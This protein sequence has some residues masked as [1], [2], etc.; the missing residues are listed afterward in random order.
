[1]QAKLIFSTVISL[2]LLSLLIKDGPAWAQTAFNVV[3]FLW[4][5]RPRAA[6]N[7]SDV[8]PWARSCQR[9]QQ[10]PTVP[11]RND[12]TQMPSPG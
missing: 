8:T 6:P 10:C 3:A 7:T 11:L 5:A 2:W 4:T 1:M 12:F 9:M